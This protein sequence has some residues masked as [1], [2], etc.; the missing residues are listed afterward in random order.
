MNFTKLVSS[1]F[2]HDLNDGLEMFVNCLEFSVAHQ[3][4]Y[5]SQPYCVLRKG[6]IGLMLFQDKELAEEHHPELRLVTDN[7]EEV[8]AK[9]SSTNPHFLH[10]NLNQ[11]TLRPWGAREFAITDKQLGIRFQQW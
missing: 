11:I 7:I 1:V 3:D 9:V 4:L 2:Y 8:F 5:T 6:Q 10:P